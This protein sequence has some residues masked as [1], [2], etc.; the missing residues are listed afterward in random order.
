MFPVFSLVLDE[1]VPA[2]IALIYP[3]LYK[4]LS[5]VGSNRNIV[6]TFVASKVKDRQPTPAP[7]ESPT[8]R[9]VLHFKDQD[10]A[11]LVRKQLKDLSQETRAVIQPVFVSN[12]IKQKLKVH[13]KKPP[14]VN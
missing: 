6:R 12:K 13:E 14:I 8:V 7:R 4:D 2:D 11:D 10:S 9:V 5:K 3:E 1:D